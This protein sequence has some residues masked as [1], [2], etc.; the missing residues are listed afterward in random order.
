MSELV[1]TWHLPSLTGQPFDRARKYVHENSLCQH[2]CF[3]HRVRYVY[4]YSNQ[5]C[6][7]FVVSISNS[8]K[9][10]K[11]KEQSF[12]DCLFHKFPATVVLVGW[13]WPFLSASNGRLALNLCIVFKFDDSQKVEGRSVCVL[14]LAKN[15]A[16]PMYTC[17]HAVKQHKRYIAGTVSVR[18]HR[19]KFISEQPK[20]TYVADDD[21]IIDTIPFHERKPVY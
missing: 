19:Q 12:W 10:V 16:N 11:K 5:V 1:Q 17:D 6:L 18:T 14:R 20:R 7:G 3:V 9:V 4:V 2:S 15:D 21:C 8:N 13:F